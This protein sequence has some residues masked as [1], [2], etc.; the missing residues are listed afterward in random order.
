MTTKNVLIV[1]DSPTQAEVLKSLLEENGWSATIARDG[2]EALLQLTESCPDVVISDIVMPRMDGYQLCRKIRGDKK[3]E[4]LPVILVTSLSDTSE[5]VKGLECGADS[6]LVKPYNSDLLIKCLDNVE[7]KKK[8]KARRGGCHVLIV[9]DSPTQAARL[10]QLILAHGFIVSKARDGIEALASIRETRPDLV[11]S[12]I[13]MPEMDGFALCE[14]IKG[15]PEL[16]SIPV[17]FLTH[18][19]DPESV[20]RAT[21]VGADEY[22]TKSFDDGYL[23]YLI[24]S[25]AKGSEGTSSGPAEEKMRYVTGGKS[26]SIS[27]ER[28]QIVNFLL[29]TYDNSVY[30]N[31]QLLDIQEQLAQTNEQL[32]KMVEERSTELENRSRIKGC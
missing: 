19:A 12:D 25:L 14:A 18:L 3:L 6:L 24:E 9:E 16:K 2:K 29:S 1:E 13:I 31:R 5:V 21:E 20:R 23:A 4:N 17:I 27:S 30:Q 7:E 15:D 10:E 28:Q 26:S 22:I 32:E 11:L 8:A